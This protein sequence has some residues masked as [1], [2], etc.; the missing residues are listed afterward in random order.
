M[1]T[2]KK[3]AAS[4]EIMPTRK[5]EIQRAATMMGYRMMQNGGYAKPFGYS[6]LTICAVRGL[7]EQWF[8]DYST[9]TKLLLWN[10]AHIEPDADPLH[11][12]K[13]FEMSE[14]KNDLPAPS[15]YDADRHHFEFAST[16]DLINHELLGA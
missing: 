11:Q 7:M 15:N 10:S 8:W 3:I 9:G 14:V 13:Q 2:D 1:S 16:A 12:I 5:M 6:V 4:P